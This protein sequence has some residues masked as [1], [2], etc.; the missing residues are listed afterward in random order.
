MRKNSF[1]QG[2]LVVLVV[3]GIMA[4]KAIKEVYA[5]A[6]LRLDAVNERIERYSA[7]A[8]KENDK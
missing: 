6:Q 5:A 2:L 8:D 3:I 4:G 7:S 1:G